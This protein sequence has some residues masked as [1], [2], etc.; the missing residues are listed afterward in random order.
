[1]RGAIKLVFSSVLFFCLIGPAYAADPILLGI[2]TSLKLI[3]GYES[4]RAAILAAEE[5]N[6]K[7]GVTVGKEKRLLKV[8]SLDIRDGEPGVPVSE[9]LLGIEKLILDKK[10]YAALVGNF[11]SEALLAA[12][13]IYSKYKVINIGSIPMSPK[14]QEKVLSNPEKYKYSFRVCLEAT[15]LSKYMSGLMKL[16]GK[17][18]GY[19]KV[20][21][22][23][24][25][26]LWATATGSMMEAW[27]KENGWTVLGFEKYP[28]GASDFSSALMKA[29]SGGAELILVVFDMPT[30][31]ILVKQWAS[32]RI[33]A[34]MAGYNGPLMGSKAWSTFGN[35]IEGSLNI[36]EDIGPIPVKAYPPATKFYEAYTKRWKESPQAGHGVGASYDAVYMLAAAIEKAGTLDPDK[37]SA[38]LAATDMAGGVVGRLKF[39]QGHQLLYGED[40][41]TGGIGVWFQWRKGERVIVYPEAVADGKIEKPVWSK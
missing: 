19:K 24:Q 38:A 15:G 13:D 28:T 22:A 26:V 5:I 25:D 39:D 36:I 14:F 21:I 30:S 37:V 10:I 12:M 6:A 33:P 11:R 2:P 4:N 35:E 31:G 18:F 29:R 17:E 3:E 40:P 34:L 23:T 9:A 8:E 20:F 32:M 1:M 16:I 41:K 27:Y 7:G